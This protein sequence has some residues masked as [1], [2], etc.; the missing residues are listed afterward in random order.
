M[1]IKKLIACF[2]VLVLTG[3]STMPLSAETLTLKE[4]L[5]TTENI[6]VR[7]EYPSMPIRI[8]VASTS[9]KVKLSANTPIC[10]RNN[11]TIS[12]ADI[13]SGSTVRFSVAQDVKSQNGATLI[14]AGTPV[15][16]QITFAKKRSYAGQSGE[17]TVSDFSTTAVD[18]T[19]VP[20]TSTLSDRPDDKVV[21]SCV[22]SVFI[23]P[24]FLLMKGNDAQVPAGTTKTSYTAS[25]VYINVNA[26]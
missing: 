17:L 5:S 10:I 12:T 13:M 16:A 24:L 21:L 14:A 19:Y 8:A 7:Q 25:E 11:E 1:H 18:G 2:L 9:G 23:C 15:T 20:L 3:F 26:Y 6:E 4:F 22:L